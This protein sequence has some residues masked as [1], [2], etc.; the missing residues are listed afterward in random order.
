MTDLYPKPDLLR[1]YA[2]AIELLKLLEDYPIIAGE[3]MDLK[4]FAG[5]GVKGYQEMATAIS[6]IVA[7]R[8]PDLRLDAIRLQR[9]LV[10][11]LRRRIAGEDI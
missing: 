1:E 8:W 11:F 7:A 9:E 4:W 5:S 6:A 2:D 3:H 10:E